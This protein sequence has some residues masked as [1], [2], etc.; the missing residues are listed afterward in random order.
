[1][2]LENLDARTIGSLRLTNKQVSY[3]CSGHGFAKLF[4]CVDFE[5]TDSGLQRLHDLAIGSCWGE[6]VERLSLST[7]R[8]KVVS[9]M[10]SYIRTEDIEPCYMKFS[11][12]VDNEN[13]MPQSDHVVEANHDSWSSWHALGL[14][15]GEQEQLEVNKSFFDTLVEIFRA[16]IKVKEISFW[17]DKSRGPL[18]SLSYRAARPFCETARL[19]FL[20]VAAI[21]ESNIVL[22]SFQLHF[23]CMNGCL[24]VIAAAPFY[25]RAIPY[26]MAGVNALMRSSRK[27][28]SADNFLKGCLPREFSSQTGLPDPGKPIPP[29]L[30]PEASNIRCLQAYIYPRHMCLDSTVFEESMRWLN[31]ET[32]SLR[33]CSIEAMDILRIFEVNGLKTVRHLEISNID[34]GDPRG[35]PTSWDRILR[36]VTKSVPSWHW[37][38]MES[39]TLGH[40]Q[41]GHLSIP[42][43]LVGE[44]PRDFRL[45]TRY[46]KVPSFRRTFSR[47]ELVKGIEFR[48]PVYYNGYWGF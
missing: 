3:C 36:Y 26:S 47:A 1:M 11:I 46:P 28:F 30:K 38:K 8:D 37:T 48:E 6:F 10:Q 33:R 43:V 13:A 7:D 25:S 40:L 14:S 24:P 17:E 20:T 4:R 21:L 27:G 9:T 42:L 22:D 32:L 44:D 29:K 41:N 18:T 16:L 39:L 19:Y 45:L 15:M 2:I 35:R 31:V 23:S 12:P 34:I 5:L